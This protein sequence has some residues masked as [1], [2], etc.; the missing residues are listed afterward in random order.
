MYFPGGAGRVSPVDP[1]DVASVARV[2]LTDQAYE[3]QAFEVTGPELLTVGEMIAILSR[4]LG[5]PPIKYVDV[6]ASVTAEHFRR[7]GASEVLAAAIIET[8]EGLRT[9]RFAYVAQTVERLTGRSGRTF[10]SWCRAN[11]AAFTSEG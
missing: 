4:V 6:P 10:E 9:G 8:L 3:R 11:A 1:F 2:V 7:Q 5:G